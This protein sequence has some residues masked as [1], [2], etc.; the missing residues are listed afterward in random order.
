MITAAAWG[1]F[2]RSRGISDMPSPSGRCTSARSKSIFSLERIF[3]AAARSAA[4]R[5]LQFPSRSTTSRTSSIRPGSSSTT[6][7]RGALTRALLAV[8]ALITGAIQY[9]SSPTNQLLLA[10]HKIATQ[11]CWHHSCLLPR[12]HR[13][14]RSNGLGGGQQNDRP[15]PLIRMTLQPNRS[16]AGFDPSQRLGQPHAPPSSGGLG[17]EERIERAL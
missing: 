8:V 7:T 14:R 6:S 10:V 11:F 17:A 15:R 4:P 1:C 5:I 16:T 12:R 13:L 9:F 3:W 2:S